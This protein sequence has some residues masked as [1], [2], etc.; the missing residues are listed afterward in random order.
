MRFPVVCGYRT[1]GLWW[2]RLFGWGVCWKRVAE[3]PLLFSERVLH[4]GWTVC[5]LHIRFLTPR[6]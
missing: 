1:H 6:G 2:F 5:G 3:H 4:R